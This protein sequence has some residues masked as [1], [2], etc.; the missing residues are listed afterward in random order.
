MDRVTGSASV[1][2][3]TR[4]SFLEG[5]GAENLGKLVWKDGMYEW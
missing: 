5:Q 4:L 3:D 1:S 2:E